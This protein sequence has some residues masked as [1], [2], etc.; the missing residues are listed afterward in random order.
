M[1][2]NQ[3]TPRRRAKCGRTPAHTIFARIEPDLGE[4]LNDYL[5]Q[6]R[7][8]TTRT[9]ILALALEEALRKAGFWPREDE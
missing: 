5:A 2:V 8:K 6:H 3:S 9:A 7:P 4:A 1:S